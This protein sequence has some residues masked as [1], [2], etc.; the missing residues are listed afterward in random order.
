M[1]RSILLLPLL[2]TPGEHAH[3]QDNLG[4]ADQFLVGNAGSDFAF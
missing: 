2:F 1:N 4:A 3:T